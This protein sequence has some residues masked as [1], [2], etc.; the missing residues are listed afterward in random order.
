MSRPLTF[1]VS[2]RFADKR[3]VVAA[4]LRQLL[5]VA[6]WPSHQ[7]EGEADLGYGV[8]A[9]TTLAAADP[10]AW[11]GSSND[12]P[13][14]R[15]GVMLPA[16]A[17]LA[18]GEID[19]VYTAHF[20]VTGQ[21]EWTETPD[22]LRHRDPDKA[23]V[24]W[25]LDRHRPVEIAAKKIT[26]HLRRDTTPPPPR[27]PW[28]RGKAWAVALTH[29]CDRIYRYRPRTYFAEAVNL[30]RSGN[31]AMAGLQSAKGLYSLA[32]RPFLADPC[33][34]AWQRMIEWQRRAGIVSATY[35]GT[36]SR[37][38]RNGH[39]DDLHYDYRDPNLARS[40]A[41]LTDSGCELG[42]HFSIRSEATPG[43]LAREIARFEEV[44]GHR[45]TGAR[46]HFWS[47][48]AERPEDTLRTLFEE[49][50][51]AYDT[52]LGMNATSGFRRGVG[53]PYRPFDPMTGKA[54][55]GFE[56]P[57][58][59]MD[60]ALHLSATTPSGRRQAFRDLLDEARRNGGLVILDWHTDAFLPGYQ[61]DC[62]P[63][64][65]S[66]IESLLAES[67]CWFARPDEI[68]AWAARD[69]WQQ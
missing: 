3:P 2:D 42:L 19:W 22:G 25:Q 53:Y 30:G 48:N 6:G 47:L 68:A 27:P 50:G 4:T 56:L 37:F 54:L 57:P 7:K 55:G 17:V 8:T 34:T 18:G 51:L 14:S 64:I 67:E 20:F 59:V 45:P 23:V 46:A 69:R 65:V 66:E 16:G 40:A 10:R 52:S 44:T 31:L 15:E 61:D 1:A 28:P 9:T 11:V 5:E 33:L 63:D 43:Q 32:A 60:E 24:R 41:S 62:F 49:C 13:V 35:F 29:D 21:H 12:Q 39:A 26:E 38:D 36:W 58:T